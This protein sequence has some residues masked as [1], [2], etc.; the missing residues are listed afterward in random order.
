MSRLSK[1]KSVFSEQPQ[2]LYCSHDTGTFYSAI[3]TTPTI[4][5]PKDGLFI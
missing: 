1:M 3:G 4:D 2:T 5:E